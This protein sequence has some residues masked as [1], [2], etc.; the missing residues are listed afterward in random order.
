[1]LVFKTHHRVKK[2]KPQKYSKWIVAAPYYTWQQESRK[3]SLRKTVEHLHE[4]DWQKFQSKH[5][6]GHGDHLSQNKCKSI[7][8]LSIFFQGIHLKVVAS[9]Q[10]SYTYFSILI[11][12]LSIRD[13]CTCAR[14]CANPTQWA[15]NSPTTRWE[16]SDS[17]QLSAPLF[18]EQVSGTNIAVTTENLKVMTSPANPETA[19]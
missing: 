7:R 8:A 17:K 14:S 16:N 9:L 4:F 6:Y 19:R 2:K 12:K 1:M 3:T 5:A 10:V 13:I 11:T 15:P 18:V